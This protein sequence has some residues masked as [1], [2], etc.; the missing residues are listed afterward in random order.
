MSRF[1]AKL[2]SV[3]WILG[4]GILGFTT[5]AVFSGVLHWHRTAFVLVYTLVVCCL[6]WVYTR[7]VRPNWQDQFQR[8]WRSGVAGGVILGGFLV[9]SVL[10][11]P[12]SARPEE[13]GVLWS[14]VR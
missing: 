7:V 2:E 9:W 12:G 10:R 3:I 14:I 8:R 5:A 13:G 11:Q 4:A 1:D 6:I